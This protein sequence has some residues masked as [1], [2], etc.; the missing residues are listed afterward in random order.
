MGMDVW[1]T[2]QVHLEGNDPAELKREY[3]SSIT[4]FGAVNCQQTL[5]FGSTEDVRKE[6][7][8]LIKILG[9]GGGYICGP[10]HSIQK[11]MPAENII[12]L[13]NEVRACAG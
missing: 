11:N 8:R 6:V 4:F 3:G 10:D 5:P 7:R 12:A 13:Y 9:K 1:E 2:V